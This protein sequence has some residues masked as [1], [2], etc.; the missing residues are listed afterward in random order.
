MNILKLKRRMGLLM[1]GDFL[2][3]QAVRISSS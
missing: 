2:F 3:P 1:D